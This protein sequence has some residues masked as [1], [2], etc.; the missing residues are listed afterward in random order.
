MHWERGGGQ[1]VWTSI[2]SREGVPEPRLPSSG[3]RRQDSVL[4]GSGGEGRG[5][6]GQGR[7]RLD[8][9]PMDAGYRPDPKRDGSLHV[10]RLELLGL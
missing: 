5:T 7:K 3:D 4:W 10:R 2:G 6:T 8:G 1:N 9:G